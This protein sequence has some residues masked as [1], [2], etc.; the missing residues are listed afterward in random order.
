MNG[1]MSGRL[2]VR[3]VNFH[4]VYCLHQFY[5]SQDQIKVNFEQFHSH[6][7]LFINL[8]EM[9][10]QESRANSKANAIT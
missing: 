8:L 7:F 5:V 10:G 9:V 4:R 6:R 2:V 1:S 3:S